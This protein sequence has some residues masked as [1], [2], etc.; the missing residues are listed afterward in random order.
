MLNV[1]QCIYIKQLFAKSWHRKR[2]LYF[3]TLYWLYFFFSL[4]ILKN[5]SY[6]LFNITNKQIK[7]VRY[8]FQELSIIRLAIRR[9]KYSKTFLI[10]AT[11]T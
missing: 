2:S 7:V 6:I 5:Y 4:L 8:S 1:E 10:L 3:V 11:L 9:R